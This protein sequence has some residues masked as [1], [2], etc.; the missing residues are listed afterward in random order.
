MNERMVG[1]GEG[2]LM[3]AGSGQ[4]RPLLSSSTNGLMWRNRYASLS[5]V[6]PAGSILSGMPTRRSPCFKHGLSGWPFP[7]LPHQHYSWAVSCEGEMLHLLDALHLLESGRQESAPVEGR[8]EHIT[9]L[10]ADELGSVGSGGRDNELCYVGHAGHSRSSQ[11]PLDEAE[12]PVGRELGV[13]R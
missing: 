11:S 9:Y 7:L 2:G 10:I 5:R 12:T 6:S 8:D 4:T 13:A 1:E 3:A